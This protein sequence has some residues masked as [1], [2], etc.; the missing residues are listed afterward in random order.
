MASIAIKNP[1][2]SLNKRLF[3]SLSD[4]FN[5]LISI[6]S[7]SEIE[8]QRCRHR[9][10]PPVRGGGGD[11]GG[12]GRVPISCFHDNSFCKHHYECIRKALTKFGS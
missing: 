7:S 10:V 11:F 1:K 6:D 5:F 4:V 9:L 3:S 8:R 2:T 12:G